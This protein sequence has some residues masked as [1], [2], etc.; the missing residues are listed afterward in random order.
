ML[1][2]NTLSNRIIIKDN[3]T[4]LLDNVDDNAICN[5]TPLLYL[6]TIII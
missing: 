3:I 6:F 5:H 1:N 2:I 4:L